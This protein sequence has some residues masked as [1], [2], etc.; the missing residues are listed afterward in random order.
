MTIEDQIIDLAKKHRIGVF[1]DSRARR[2]G[3]PCIQFMRNGACLAEF[4]N[5]AD[6]LAW[7]SQGTQ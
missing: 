5:P 3:L 7:L 6:A 1:F 4:Y 2:N